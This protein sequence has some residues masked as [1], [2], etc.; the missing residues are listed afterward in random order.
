[1]GRSRGG[2]SRCA[3]R[4]RIAI[5]TSFSIN[6]PRFSINEPGSKHR[7]QLRVLTNYNTTTVGKA[8]EG[9]F[10]DAKWS[11]FDTPKGETVVQ[12]DG[13]VQ[14]GLLGKMT[15]DKLA[16]YANLTETFHGFTLLDN[17]T[18]TRK[19]DCIASLGVADALKKDTG[20][21]AAVGAFG[22]IADCMNNAVIPVKFQFVL[23]ADNKTFKLHYV[24]DA[25][26][27]DLD[28]ALPFIYK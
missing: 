28:R 25:F 19:N 3:C 1:M 7:A 23:S 10:Q 24:D 17:T 14:F 15:A 8:F 2:R 22:K 16:A 5:K 4:G 27:N 21:G 11:S 18:N 26:G 12:F 6:E 20:N 13:T 9:T